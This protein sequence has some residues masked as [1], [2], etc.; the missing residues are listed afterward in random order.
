M[1]KK[2]LAAS[3][4]PEDL[5]EAWKKVGDVTLRRKQMT[6]TRSEAGW[7]RLR[8]EAPFHHTSS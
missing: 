3:T 6:L 4:L 5:T 2:I 8:G 1:T 7:A